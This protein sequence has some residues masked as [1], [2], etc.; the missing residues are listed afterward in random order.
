[1]RLLD[2]TL[3]QV[4][5]FGDARLT[6]C[7]GPDDPVPVA[8]VTGDNG[9]GKT[10]ILDAIRGL[11]GAGY[12]NLERPIV[13]KGER[14]WLEAVAAF[15]GVRQPMSA[16]RTLGAC[17]FW[18][19]NGEIG[20][21]PLFVQQGRARCPGWV[22]DYWRPLQAAGASEARGVVTPDARSYLL[23]ALSGARAGGA[24][25]ELLCHFDYVRTS[26]EPRERRAGEA[27][28]EAAR[29]IVRTIV[30]GAELA[31]VMRR[32]LVPMVER[33]GRRVPL[34]ALGSGVVWAVQGA[35]GLLGRMYAVHV[36]LDTEPE[37]IVQTPGLLLVDDA[38][39]L[40]DPKRQ[41]RFLRDMLR[42]FPGLQIVATTRSPLVAASVPGARVF[43]CRFEEGKEGAVIEESTGARVLRD[44]TEMLGMMPEVGE[45]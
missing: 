24:M 18:T 41:A 38:E 16:E 17:D 28:W 11:F 1:M 36:L 23:G 14:F 22:V 35:I 27:V 13:R 4:G 25:T 7:E 15:A 3:H 45:A 44:A 10:M 31:D 32:Q 8:I 26:A 20:D 33:G 12:G 42:I 19:E 40:L 21:L 30:P 43:V 9:T 34:S 37:E 2:L 29:E 39:G 6:L 5:P